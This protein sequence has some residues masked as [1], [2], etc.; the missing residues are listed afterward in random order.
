MKKVV[1]IL[2]AVGLLA[3]CQNE[4][5]TLIQMTGTILNPD[6][7]EMFLNQGRTRDTIE[8]AEDGTFVYE[9]ESEKAISANLT[10]GRKRASLW[11]SPGK[12]LELT[13]DVND[14]EQSLGFGGDLQTV[15]EYLIAK[16][17]VQM[18]WGINY[19][20]NFQKAPE[21]FK[22]SR[23]S[24]QG[25]FV[26]LLEEFKSQGLDREFVDVE[27]MSLQYTE[28][29]DLNNY[30]RNHEY[31]AKVENL[32]LPNDWYDFTSD[33]DL[34]D[35]LL[36]EVNEAMYFLSSWVNTE[37][38]KVAGLGDDAWGTPELLA[39]KL[40]FIDAKFSLAEMVEK[41]KFENLNQ[42]LDG[43]PPT[44][45][46]DAIAGYLAA[47]T[48]E[49]NKKT[50]KE[51]KDAWA[52]IEV[53][54]VAPT[55][56]LPDIDGKTMSL[57][58]FKGKYVYIDF[59][60]TWCGPCIAEIPDYRELVKEYADR[61]IV[62]VSISV[63]KDKPKW[64]EMVKAEKFDWVQLHD[65]EMMNDDYLVRYIPTFVLIDTEGKII[66]PR[67]PR[68]SEPKLRKMLDAQ[69]NL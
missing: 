28:Y 23:D 7:S 31:Y 5:N 25:V 62:F 32:E 37:A 10:Y 60:A 16:G 61:N 55:W 11:L 52:S 27:Q 30:P 65:A 64:E 45:A 18:G 51:K 9:T 69:E 43:G 35:P 38:P 63:D 39:A 68:P 54:Q 15:H 19:M 53:G 26:D 58:D 33:M 29:G 3:S 36:L 17:I 44:G 49:E 21:Q 2:M 59:W 66:D 20:A 13:A 12:T 34:D 48:N 1:L 56:T 47:S 41:F 50:I 42:H 67:A 46:E 14:W 40:D 57:A 6:G 8:I 4:P 22:A 24:L